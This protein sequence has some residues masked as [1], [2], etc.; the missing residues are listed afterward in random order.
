MQIPLLSPN[1]KNRLKRLDL[2]SLTF[3]PL[4][5]NPFLQRRQTTETLESPKETFK[6]ARIQQ[7]ESIQEPISI[8][9]PERTKSLAASSLFPSQ[10]FAKLDS[11]KPL[12]SEFDEDPYLLPTNSPIQER[13][14]VKLNSNPKRFIR[15]NSDYSVDSTKAGSTQA[16]SSKAIV[17]PARLLIKGLEIPTPSNRAA[18]NQD[19]KSKEETYAS[20]IK[21]IFRE[22]A[23]EVY[24]PKSSDVSQN[25]K[26]DRIIPISQSAMLVTED[27]KALKQFIKN[28]LFS[29]NGSTPR[30]LNHLQTKPKDQSDSSNHSFKLKIKESPNTPVMFKPTGKPG[31]KIVLSGFSSPR[32]PKNPLDLK[33]LEIFKELKTTI[34]PEFRKGEDT[35][36]YQKVAQKK[37]ISTKLEDLNAV[38]KICN[39]VNKKEK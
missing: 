29:P 19:Q 3:K 11:L 30:A 21:R 2:E 26:H 22:E 17:K 23:L 4:P 10:N 12:K 16:R 37:T 18:N 14:S 6:S 28:G 31:R 38:K 20:I 15:L 32:S 8:K 13:D 9:E 34:K 39:K 35:P 25:Q 24:S 27:P 1:M 33:S 36:Y 7:L 5:T